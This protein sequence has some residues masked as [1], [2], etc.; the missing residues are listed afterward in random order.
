MIF[1]QEKTM[2]DLYAIRPQGATVS[3][4]KAW[5][6]GHI[7]GD[8]SVTYKPGR[9]CQIV[10]AAGIHREDADVVVRKFDAVYG[11]YASIAELAPGKGKRT[12]VNYI[13]R[14]SWRL[15]VEDV[16]S[17]GIFGVYRW[18]V[19]G[20][21]LASPLDVQ[22]GWVSGFSDAEGHVSYLPE[23]FTRRIHIT[24]VNREGLE[25]VSG[26]LTALGVD[27]RWEVRAP[28]GNCRESY[29]LAVAY[30][31]AVAR[32]AEVVGFESPRKR[33]TLALALSTVQRDPIHR[34]AIE[35]RVDEIRSR[36][37]IGETHAEI[38]ETLGFKRE[39]VAH[40][41]YRH[42]I[43]P[44]GREGNAD[45]GR[46][47]IGV[48]RV[49]RFLPCVLVL[50]GEGL[51]HGEIARVLE[52]GGAHVVQGL[53]GRAAR[54]GRI[55]PL[56]RGTKQRDVLPRIQNMRAQGITFREIGETL[57]ERRGHKAAIWAI[58]VARWGKNRAEGAVPEA[59]PTSQLTQQP[60]TA[61]KAPGS[62]ETG[63]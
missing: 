34:F 10:V 52:L 35:D 12:Q 44:E 59:E 8:G 27:H 16:L 54:K 42:G 6:L 26:I 46:R 62:G 4:D 50:K 49:E 57:S 5:L 41:C 39:G 29:K 33:E 2:G 37:E 43:E 3:R 36:R 24:S 1:S 9:V 20:S 31:R 48:G 15:M 55:S 19:P 30:H 17:H 45:K 25:Q 14:C 18:R 13:V 7:A 32:F 53:L 28:R 61:H 21:V 58:G 23:T 11:A 47:S 63:T 56:Q 51:S 22:A 38:A 60:G 40:A